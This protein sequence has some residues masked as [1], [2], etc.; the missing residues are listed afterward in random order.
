MSKFNAVYDKIFKNL[1]MIIPLLQLLLLE[2][3]SHRIW[4]NT[5]PFL[6]NL[7]IFYALFLILLVICGRKGLPIVISSVL[8]GGIGLADAMLLQFRQTPILPWD[9]LSVKT[10]LSVSSGYHL[11]LTQRIILSLA[12]FIVFIVLGFFL[13]KE[14]AFKTSKKRIISSIIALLLSV[15]LI[16]V[17]PLENLGKYIPMNNASFLPDIQYSENGFVFSFLRALKDIK[18]KKPEGYNAENEEKTIKNA[19]NI[20]KPEKKPNIIV[21]MNEAFS[22]LSVLDNEL[23]TNKEVLPFISSLNTN[24]VKGKAIVSVKGGNTANSEF[25]FLTS[26]PVSFYPSGT[27]PY[28]QYVKQNVYSLPDYLKQ[29]N[30]DT[31]AFH[32]AQGTNWKRNIVYPYLGFDNCFFS[33]NFSEIKIDNPETYRGIISDKTTYDYL[34][35]HYEKRDKN[36]NFF[37]F[38]VTLQN[39]GGYGEDVSAEFKPDIVA[40]EYDSYNLNTYLSL[41]NKSDEAFK[42][43][44]EY[45]TDKEPTVILMFGDHQPADEVTSVLKGSSYELDKYTVPYV[46]WANYDID[47]SNNY[48]TTSLNY[49]SLLLYEKAGI[50]TDDD[51]HKEISDFREKYPVISTHGIVDNK[52]KVYDYNEIDNSVDFLKY[53]SLNY[54]LVLEKKTR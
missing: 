16:I 52:G 37:E 53:R 25:E 34:I 13:L 8:W 42:Y 1:Y 11:V 28:Q 41:I 26:M 33:E 30:Y 44:T 46:L 21:I 9:I 35:N 45:F 2:L 3:F 5:G 19:K 38:C 51:F 39:H 32:P 36:K 14:K 4:M 29:F 49:L 31:Y 23:K 27:V 18:I 50:S 24:T 43:L 48:E 47:V 7:G 40:S 20:S 6:L 10:A 12:C 54:Y 17:I 15:I 22:D